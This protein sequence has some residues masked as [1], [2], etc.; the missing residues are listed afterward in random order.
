MKVLRDVSTADSESGLRGSRR[1]PGSTARSLEIP[2][3]PDYLHRGMA[4]WGILGHSFE[5]M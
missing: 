1:F 2:V 4:N 3:V 5:E